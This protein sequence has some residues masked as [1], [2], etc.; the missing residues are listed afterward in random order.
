MK[1]RLEVE[2]EDQKKQKKDLD[3][4]QFYIYS[5]IEVDLKPIIENR[6]GKVIDSFDDIPSSNK[7]FVFICSHKDYLYLLSKKDF[8]KYQK[9]SYSPSFFLKNPENKHFTHFLN[10]TFFYKES[11]TYFGKDEDKIRKM[12]KYFKGYWHENPFNQNSEDIVIRIVDD[13]NL[14]NDQ[15]TFDYIFQP[16][17]IY[18]LSEI[19]ELVT[20]WIENDDYKM[21]VCGYDQYSFP[22]YFP[23]RFQF[24]DYN[25]R[26]K[27]IDYNVIKKINMNSTPILPQDL[28]IHIYE[29]LPLSYHLEMRLLSK[30]FNFYNEN[31][32]DLNT[33]KFIHNKLKNYKSAISTVRKNFNSFQFYHSIIH[34]LTK[35]TGED[36]LRLIFDLRF[37]H[38]IVKGKS[39]FSGNPDLPPNYER[40]PNLE[41]IFQINF[42]DPSLHNSIVFNNSDLP[43]SGILYFF[44]D[45][46]TQNYE[47]E[48][49]NGK[50]EDLIQAK[51]NK[52]SQGCHMMEFIF[53]DSFYKSNAYYY[54]EIYKKEK[55]LF[56]IS[57][58]NI[59]PWP[60]M[61]IRL[62]DGMNEYFY[63]NLNVIV[64]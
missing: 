6:G 41:F 54:N 37:T 24:E 51:N 13:L 29:F 48:F 44:A 50:I 64:K 31:Y 9:D 25:Y 36:Y 18:L 17:I 62:N 8:D 14:T 59:S 39:R 53:Y 55:T 20:K 28:I 33:D 12:I 3:G 30:E 61:K 26:F 27:K 22:E 7:D 45:F 42:S 40:K 4:I 15:K 11:F 23:G 63:K 58:S 5:K 47:F 19:Q 2:K 16:G 1:R 52:N 56:Q 38:E 60:N 34:P 43:R 35:E 49:Y 57:C 46:M 21:V 10:N 32:W